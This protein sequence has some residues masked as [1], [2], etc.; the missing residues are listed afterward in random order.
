MCIATEHST[1]HFDRHDRWEVNRN[2]IRLPQA[3]VHLLCAFDIHSGCLCSSV[4]GAKIVLPPVST[5]CKG[6]AGVT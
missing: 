2:C 6:S 1:F 5:P 4:L 3:H